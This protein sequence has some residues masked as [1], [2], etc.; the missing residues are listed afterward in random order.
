[1][2]IEFECNQRFQYVGKIF[3]LVA[4]RDTNNNF[5][6]ITFDFVSVVTFDMNTL[7]NTYCC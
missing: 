1:M 3:L 2:S 5:T 4:K 6:P 7:K